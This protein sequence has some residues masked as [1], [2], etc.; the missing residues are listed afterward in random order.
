MLSGRLLPTLTEN[1]SLVLYFL[2]GG[3]D[4]PLLPSRCF[5]GVLDLDLGVLDLDLDVLDPELDLD[6]DRL[7]LYCSL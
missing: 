5:K 4:G 3:S 6:R 1:K 7:M 2:G